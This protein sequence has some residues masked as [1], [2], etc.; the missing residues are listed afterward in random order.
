MINHATV[1]PHWRAYTEHSFVQ[2]LSD[3]SLPLRAFKKFL[4]Q[5]YLYLIHYARLHALAAYKCENLDDIAGSAEIIL[6]IRQELNLHLEYCAVFG[7]TRKELEE[8]EE[9]VAC[10]VYTRYIESIG[11]SR[12]WISLLVAL[13]ACLVG[14]GE[15][16]KRLYESTET[17]RQSRYWTWIKNYA[18]DDYSAAVT[19]GR[20]LV[21]KHAADQS[22]TKIAELVQIFRRVTE[23]EALF[24]TS[25][26]E[27]DENE[28]GDI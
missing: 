20:A 25:A 12:D 14:Y 1:Q 10:T 24:W 2:Q 15:V 19:R 23:Y 8:G 9:T 26:L 18:E 5:D 16:R 3:G 21:E 22:P 27:L 28:R 7:I 11:T 17:N 4:R 6:H 13:T